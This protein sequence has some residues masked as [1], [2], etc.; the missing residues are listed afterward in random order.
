MSSVKTYFD[1]Q[2]HNHA[3]HN[4]PDIYRSIV[5]H[6]SKFPEGIELKIFD[7]GCGD[8]SFIVSLINNINRNNIGIYYFGT[9][10]S[11]TM[12]KTANERLKKNKVFLFVG[13]GFN[14]PLNEDLKFD[15]IHIDSV[16]HHL[17]GK[18]IDE[19]KILTKKIMEI[20]MKKLKKNGALILEEV[21]Y[22]SYIKSDLTS[23]LIFYGLKFL[24]KININIK[25]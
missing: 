21:F 13:D 16:I 15:C 24:N 9:D 12:I 23:I 3:Y 20:M 8:G 6:I 22:D 2:G 25:M 14:L 18:D 11:E 17:I 1:T 7:V 5:E 4:D 10:I 19:S